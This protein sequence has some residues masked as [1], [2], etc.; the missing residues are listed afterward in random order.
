[1]LKGFTRAAAFTSAFRGLFPPFLFSSFHLF[2][3][4]FAFT[5]QHT[6]CFD[7][8]AVA[9]RPFFA[10]PFPFHM[11]FW[12]PRFVSPQDAPCPPVFS[13]KPLNP[14]RTP[15]MD[16][17]FLCRSFFPVNPC[18]QTLCPFISPPAPRRGLFSILGLMLVLSLM[19]GLVSLS[20]L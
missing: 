13:E 8:A 20:S 15:Y 17:F 11:F 3:P 5:G 7:T 12:P 10:C 4:P 18:F 1:M 19:V 9:S 14:I 2:P 16:F 6:L